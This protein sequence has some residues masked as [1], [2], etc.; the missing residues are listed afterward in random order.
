[1]L[2]VRKDELIAPR[3]DTVLLV[4]DHVFVFCRPEDRPT[5]DLLFGSEA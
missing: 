3:G 2:I 5:V 1:M 4:G